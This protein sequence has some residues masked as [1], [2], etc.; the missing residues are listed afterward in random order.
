M[1]TEASDEDGKRRTTNA[2]FTPRQ[3][4]NDGPMFPSLVTGGRIPDQ[5]SEVVGWI[6]DNRGQN[7]SFFMVLAPESTWTE[8]NS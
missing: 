6:G 4:K 7:N 2:M 5:D 3:K 1:M 8:R